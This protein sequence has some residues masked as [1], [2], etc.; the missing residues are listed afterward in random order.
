MLT[1]RFECVASDLSQSLP[2]SACFNELVQDLDCSILPIRSIDGRRGLLDP[3]PPVFL[4]NSAASGGLTCTMAPIADGTAGISASANTAEAVNLLPLHA[5]RTLLHV[6]MVGWPH[7]F[8]SQME[9]PILLKSYSPDIRFNCM[10][11][12]GLRTFQP[13][14]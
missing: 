4:P 2:A 8:W 1:S 6:L 13:N 14:T 7:C 10:V 5:A 9:S 12:S 11:R 3:H